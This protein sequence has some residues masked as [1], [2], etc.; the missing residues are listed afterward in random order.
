MRCST[1]QASDTILGSGWAT[2]G[3]TASSID[4]RDR[5][6][7]FLLSEGGWPVRLK[8]YYLSDDD[9][10]ILAKRAEALRKTDEE[11]AS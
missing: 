11:R 3:F 10:R 8:A 1:P 6:V 5:G 2:Q 7:G 9:L 4:G